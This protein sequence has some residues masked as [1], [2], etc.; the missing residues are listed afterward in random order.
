MT[1][2]WRSLVDQLLENAQ[3]EGAFDRLPGTGKP[4]QFEDESHIPEELRMAHRLL[5]E[6]DLVPEWIM[7]AKD[8]DVMQERLIKTMRRGLRAYQ[9]VLGD[10]DR[11]NDN[12][13][14]QKAQLTWRRTQQSYAELGAKLNREILR[15]NLKVPPG[16]PQRALFDVERELQK[17]QD[18]RENRG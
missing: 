2:Q 10:A 15:Y 18:S 14:R 9:G 13:R 11:A 7:M 12:D 3:N 1:Q 4:L 6:H 5:K 17:L 16:F 8:I